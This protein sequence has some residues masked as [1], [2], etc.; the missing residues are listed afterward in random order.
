MTSS[1]SKH[2]FLCNGATLSTPVSED[3][4][5]HE[6]NYLGDEPNVRIK[7]AEFVQDVVHLPEI[8]LDLLE[9]AAYVFAADRSA[10]RGDK[11][12]LEYHRWGRFMR[13]AIKVRKDE[14]WNR[15]EI[16][17]I[18]SETL[19][20]MTGDREYKFE[21]QPGHRTSQQ[22]L[23][24]RDDFNLASFY[25]KDKGIILFS[26]GLDSLAGTIKHV[27]ENQERKIILVSHQSGQPGT[28]RTQDRLFNA[29][30]NKYLDRVEHYKFECSLKGYRAIE[31]T[32]RT[33]AFLYCAVAFA[34][35]FS[36][37]TDEFFFYEN[38]V[39]SLNLPRQRQDMMN[40]R[41]SRTTHPKTLRLMAE[42]LSMVAREIRNDQDISIEIQNPFKWSTKADVLREIENFNQAGLIS[43]TV[44]CSASP[45]Q[46]SN[47]SNHCGKCF[48]CVDRRIAMYAVG[49]QEWD[50][51][52]VY[53]TRFEEDLGEDA[54]PTIG[55]IGQALGFGKMTEDQFHEKYFME[56]EDINE[57]F[58]NIYSLAQK[59]S[60][61]VSRGL[62]SIRGGEDLSSSVPHKSFYGII[63][64]R[65]YLKPESQ[66]MAEKLSE[67]FRQAIPIAF[68][69][70]KPANEQQLNDYVES[71]LANDK[72]DLL[73]EFPVVN[74]GTT[75]VVPDHELREYDLLIECKYPRH[76]R[77][78]SQI[79]EEI[80]ADIVQF[81]AG[82]FIL[83]IVYDPSSQIS[84]ISEF[85]S[86][87]SEKA[88]KKNTDSLV[89][90]I[91]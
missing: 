39:T 41:A 24:D 38:G 73:R 80:A 54:A 65:E 84:N 18:L 14:F 66:R 23:F 10:T 59:H 51:G 71:V 31:E 70:Q 69:K 67:R 45:Y 52:G 21:F 12:L 11:N 57:N 91:R 1:A 61:D 34:I 90:V 85:E 30:R 50:K 6:F 15:E 74:F 58:E 68:Q 29:L 88:R 64:E 5:E 82:V 37:E 89:C 60:K 62:L 53:G 87:I 40:S 27:S 25:N 33:R 4:K 16:K 43:S 75:K 77:K 3:T 76:T 17:S 7:L 55:Y 79:N 47:S 8:I 35:S 83:F 28:K 22:G 63:S 46:R 26:G 78:L 32:Q 44:S 36:L 42:F 19:A 86:D 81:P 72:E 20:F 13:F 2:V 9:I 49:I 48:Q 56:L